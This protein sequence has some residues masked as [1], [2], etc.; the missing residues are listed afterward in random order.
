MADI[1]K[2]ILKL[3]PDGKISD[4]AFEAANIVLYTKDRDYF[5]D[6]QG[7]IRAVVEQ[8]KKRI[9]VRADAALTIDPEKAEILIR[10]TI[11]AEAGV[12][13]IIFDSKRSRVIIHAEKPGL[14]IGKMGSVLQEIKAKTFWVPI[15]KRTPPIRS[16]LIEN[17]RAVLYQNSDERRRFLDRVGHRIYDGWMREKKNEWIRISYLGSGREVGRSCL[18][19]QTSESRILMDCG[20]NVSSEKDAFPF[21]EAPEF[22]LNQVDAVIITHAHFDHTGM[23]PYLIKMGYK[24]PIY[25]TAPTRDVAALILLDYVKM[26]KNEGKEPLYTSEEIKNMVKQTIC[27][28]WGEVTDITPDV[29]LTFYNSGH[30]LGSSMAHMHIGNGLHNMMYTG[31]MK[32]NRTRLLDGCITRFPR[33]ETVLIESTYG[34]KDCFLAPMRDSDEHLRTIIKTTFERGGKLLI[35]ALAS[36]RAQEIMILIETLVRTGQLDKVPVYIDGM[37]WD[38]AAIHTAYPEFLNVAIRKQIF[39]K[40]NNPFLSE[41]FHRIGSAKER[42]KVI[43]ETG[44]CIILATSGMLEGG[45]IMEYLRQLGD[46]PHN[47][48]VFTCYQA[49]GTLGQRIKAGLREVVFPVGPKK[50]VVE[51]KLEVHRALEISAHADRRELFNFVNRCSPRPKKVIVNH[52]ESSRCIDLASGIHKQFKIETAAPRNLD[53]IRLR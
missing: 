50:E 9:E 46:N 15:I 45:P 18:F 49:E 52:G 41:I 13:D 39:H 48:M 19:L 25:M 51:L 21:F 1:L 42:Q 22:D 29:R 11:P 44:S 38:I 43:E 47:A 8:M 16:Q 12:S 6:N 4:T 10:E 28:D 14:A 3:L 27:L 30:I 7:T 37:L 36:G 35:P 31:D 5:L 20:I 24:G 17:I 34:G 23:I 26:M 53:T 2:E 32:F 33:L 40:D